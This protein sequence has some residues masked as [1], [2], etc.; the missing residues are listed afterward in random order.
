MRLCHLTGRGLSWRTTPRVLPQLLRLS[1]VGLLLWPALASAAPLRV[2]VAPVA[3]DVGSDKVQA[4][5]ETLQASGLQMIPADEVNKA[6]AE[7]GANL[8]T[9]G[10]RQRVLQA[11]GADGLLQTQLGRV[12][13]RYSAK[14]KLYTPTGVKAVDRLTLRAKRRTRL[15]YLMKKRL[16]PWIMTHAAA[17]RPAEA[18]PALAQTPD[19]SPEPAAPLPPTVT[20]APPPPVVIKAPPPTSPA[21]VRPAPAP[22]PPA[23]VATAS[24]TRSPSPR[25]SLDLGVG[26]GLMSRHLAYTDDLFEALRPYDLSAAPALN[27]SVT[28]YPA[29]PFTARWPSALG[30][31]AR[32][33]YGLG[34]SSRDSADRSYG[35]QAVAIDAAARARLALG[36]H[37]VGLAAG[38]GLHRFAVQGINS[39]Q[40]PAFPNVNY[41]FIRV[42]IDARIRPLPGL[43]I[44]PRVGWRQVLSA[45]EIT[46][47][48]WFPRASLLAFDAELSVAYTITS[49]LELQA[50]GGL[51]R[52]AYDL[53]VQPEDPFIAGGA[54]DQYLSAEVLVAWFYGGP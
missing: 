44:R 50:R 9:A 11:L 33:Q 39:A 10:G 52:Y 1:V 24:A 4:Q 13:G 2:A 21:Q 32:L 6:M 27:L 43:S 7:L 53:G 49:S 31:E 38:G 51:Q 41:A 42:G 26:L 16:G 12:R 47:S 5:L 45:G 17:L 22:A 29:A 28:W 18:P 54:V 25:R 35:T 3:P 36:R 40:D 37:E 20:Q 19:P 30:L 48:A 46:D 34:I 15:T 8:D 23:Q 14:L